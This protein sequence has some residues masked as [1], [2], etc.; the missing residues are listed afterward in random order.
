M[1]KQGLLA[2]LIIALAVSGLWNLS[3][4]L[5]QNNTLSLYQEH[6]ELID[7]ILEG[8]ER[9]Q[10]RFY[11]IDEV[12]EADLF[13][14]S[15]R[16]LMRQLDDPYSNYFSPEEFERFNR[17]LEGEFVGVGIHIGIR[18]DRVTIVSPIQDSPAH[19]AGARAG[20]IILFIDDTDTEGMTL[21]E[22]VSLL[23]GQRGTEVTITV[24]HRDGTVEE[25]LVV[26]DVIRVP[27]VEVDVLEDDTIGYI[28]LFTF[29]E[30]AGQDVREAL[31]D[32][33]RQGVEGVIFDLRDNGGGLLG[34][35]IDISS[36]FV[37]A[38]LVLTTT[39][40]S[41]TQEYNS[42]GNSWRNVP[43]AVLINGGSASASEIVAGAVQD[44]QMGILVGQQSFGKGVVQTLFPLDDGSYLR[45]TTSEYL[46]PLGR[47]VQGD[48][49]TPDLLVA[50]PFE[51]VAD[52]R[53]Q[54][55]E[56]KMTLYTKE[57]HMRVNAMLDQLTG[58]LNHIEN[59]DPAAETEATALLADFREA[60]SMLLS[61]S[62]GA[63]AE[64]LMDVEATLVALEDAMIHSSINT[65]INWLKVNASQVCPCEVSSDIAQP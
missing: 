1:N 17:G 53:F 59:D 52:A 45:L 9:V 29:N 6:Q 60:Q 49:L 13:Q 54:I 51:L 57:A 14:G 63:L 22:A 26:R 40:P 34:E 32:F 48:G 58:I 19:Q 12:N 10:D 24:L 2:V 37:D 23:R 56:L 65:A 46:T 41:G 38:G 64:D 5:G 20:D 39:G 31:R 27:T 42:R 18:D 7:P 61:A 44:T 55:M 15:L 30:N 47:H 43:V 3:F 62:E 35:A 28:R 8:F 11:R 16:G 50:D 25:L 36:Q 33:H 21:D 4:M